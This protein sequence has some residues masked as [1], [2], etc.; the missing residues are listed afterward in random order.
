MRLTL[1]IQPLQCSNQQ[2][3]YGAANEQNDSNHTEPKDSRRNHLCKIMKLTSKQACKF[4]H[5]EHYSIALLTSGY[6]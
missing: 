6:N 4:S 2:L 5:Y 3:M 1:I